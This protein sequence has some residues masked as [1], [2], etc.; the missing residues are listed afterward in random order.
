MENVKDIDGNSYKI[1]KI[2]NQIWMTENLK[3]T[4]YRNNDKI[5]TEY[6]NNDWANLSTGA[7]AVNDEHPLYLETYGNL[8]NWYAVDDERGL[9]P[10]GWH[11][12]TEDEFKQLEIYLGLNEQEVE[13]VG[14]RGTNLGSML[15]GGSEWF[16]DG[17]LKDNLLFGTSGFNGLPAG[18]RTFNDGSYFLF[19]IMGYFWSSTEYNKKNAFHRKLFFDS[20]RVNR[21]TFNKKYGF[22]VRCVKD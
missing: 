14:D 13:S 11:I 20:S 2:G 16:L 21:A 19:G 10:D 12:P 18:C 4:C 6:S 17:P 22:S 3:V 1:V 15:A 8:Y 7:Y 9:A 5:P